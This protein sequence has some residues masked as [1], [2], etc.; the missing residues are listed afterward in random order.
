[1]TQDVYI[2]KKIFDNNNSDMQFSKLTLP[3]TIHF[4]G[5]A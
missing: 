3:E 4:I 5:E 1:M 2:I